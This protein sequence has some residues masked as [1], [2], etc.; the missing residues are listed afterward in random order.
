[1]PDVPEP[2]PVTAIDPETRRRVRALW[3]EFLYEFAAPPVQRWWLGGG[4]P[5]LIFSFVEL[6][7]GYFDD[8]N[9]SE[10]LEAAVRGGWMTAAEA[11]ASREFHHLAARYREPPGEPESVLADPAWADVVEAARRAWFAIREVTMDPETLVAMDSMEAEWGRIEPVTGPAPCGPRPLPPRSA[12]ARG[13]RIG[14]ADPEATTRLTPLEQLLTL[15]PKS[16]CVV[17]IVLFVGGVAACA[18]LWLRGWIVGWAVLA[19]ILGLG[20]SAVG[21]RDLLRVRAIEAETARA[22]REWHELA[23]AVEA[24]KREGKNVAR[25]LQGR[26]YQVFEVRRWILQALGEERT[27]R[28]RQR[29]VR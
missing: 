6:M 21:R 3:I 22:R 20:L 29:R 18:I 16:K 1:M 26:G 14:S 12:P 4:P 24:T 17:G 8:L 15:S 23:L 5:G 27:D 19:V 25:F 11:Q 28:I 2:Q 13:P 9:M 7:C 10:G